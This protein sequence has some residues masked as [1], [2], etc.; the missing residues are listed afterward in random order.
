MSTNSEVITIDYVQKNF[1][2]RKNAIT[3]EIVEIL[4]KA[5]EEP[6]FQ[7]ESL[8]QTAITYEAVMTRNKVG[9]K[10]YLNAIRFCSY[11]ISLDDN[12]TEAYKKTFFDRKFVRDRMDEPTTSPKY[13]E[14][15]SA[16][17]RYRRSRLVVD[18]LTM[19]QVPL[20]LL[21]TGYRYKAIG[22][23]ADEMVNAAYSKDRINAAKELLAATK[24]PD[25]MKI[26]LDVG[27]RES[28]AVQSL[29]DQ[30]AMIAA[31]QKVFLETGA[32]SLNELGAMRPK[33]EIVEA[34]VL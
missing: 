25:N 13:N 7:G 14:L 17:S 20:D 10:D 30:L 6:E 11:L 12:Y 22:V 8:L 9:M 19:S 16:A 15:T 5:Q 31:K 32:T 2:T 28:S 21:F 33:E 26:E 24:G 27:V 3:D 29:N 23:L 4:N 18:I 34:E 1:P